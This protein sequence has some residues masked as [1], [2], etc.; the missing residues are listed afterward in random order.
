[1]AHTHNIVDSDATF[2]IDV[3]TRA[4]TTKSD[5]L[6]LVQYDHE[7]ERYTFKIPRLIEEHDTSLCDRIEVHFSNIAKSKKTRNDDVYIVPKADVTNDE[8][9]VYFSWLVSREATQLFGTLRFSVTFICLDDND[10][11]I[12]EWGTDQFTNIQILEKSKHT[13]TVLSEHP[14]LIEHIKQE[15]LEELPEMPDFPGGGPEYDPEHTHDEYAAKDHNHDETY[16]EKDHNHD[17]DY[18][19]KDHNHDEDYAA[20][21]HN[22]DEDYAAKDHTHEEYADKEHTHEEYADKEHNH[23]ETY[24]DKDHNHDETYAEKNHNHDDVYG[25]T[26]EI[27]SDEPA[28]DKTVLTI[29][30]EAEEVKIYTAEE[31]DRMLEQSSKEISDVEISQEK[32][33]SSHKINEMFTTY[34][35]EI[36]NL[37]GGDA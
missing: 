1:M 9:N 33:W 10:N 23:D 4:I 35:D 25:G 12:Y 3:I 31:V 15:V 24:A 32:T 28:K 16:A 18:A 27:T 29:D 5:K 37:V 14:D 30:P 22:H 17:E 34:V 7:S 19:A 8:D 36:A 6:Y 2:D 26:I 13:E 11:V 21:D 20:K